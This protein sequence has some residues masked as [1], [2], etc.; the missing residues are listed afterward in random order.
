MIRPN[1]R[2]Q[3]TGWLSALNSW[4]KAVT[5]K[6]TS[7]NARLLFVVDN[8][9]GELTMVMFFL[10]GRKLAS[11]TTL[12]LPPRLYAANH[13]VLP[14][15]TLPY[16]SYQELVQTIDSEDPDIVFLFSGYLLALHQLLSIDELGRLVRSLRE[17][18]RSVATYDPFWG[19]ML[20]PLTVFADHLLNDESRRWSMRLEMY[21]LAR[22][23]P[24][25]KTLT[26]TAAI[27]KELPHVNPA[28]IKRDKV[29]TV[30]FFNPGL[31]QTTNRWP[32]A[33]TVGGSAKPDTRYW[34]FVLS[35]ED[36]EKQ[37]AQR[38][39]RS[40]AAG[41]AIRPQPLDGRETFAELTFQTLQ[42]TSRAGR[43]PIL[44]APEA[45]LEAVRER[46][47]N[48]EMAEL[49]SFCPYDRFI[50]LLLNAEYVF[51]WNAISSS[52]LLRVVNGLPVFYFDRGHV[53]DGL[54]LVYKSTV[55]F[56]YAGWEPHYLDQ[57]NELNAEILEKLTASYKHATAR[58]RANLES[59]STPEQ[60]VDEILSGKP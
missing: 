9:Y 60:L 27:L 49:V 25:V 34:L 32:G 29:R 24:V 57:E 20:D 6:T 42:Q 45:C 1:P 53:E 16:R 52:C 59:A 46:M 47:E 14:V 48:S 56:F 26:Q 58:I 38:L 55:E 23:A 30:S 3:R 17:R 28:P 39:H 18:G 31:L 35:V 41:D 44:L 12:L 15:R 51:Y 37:K 8:D 11:R 43:R 40:W 13:A 19:L 36:F 7:D 50:P 21:E 33:V 2:R 10:Q 4:I 5:R 22:A 54:P